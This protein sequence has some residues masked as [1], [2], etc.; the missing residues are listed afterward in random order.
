MFIFSDLI[1]EAMAT[2]IRPGLL[3]ALTAKPAAFQYR[4]NALTNQIPITVAARAGGREDFH[5][6]GFMASL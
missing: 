3:F 1:Y 5:L 4:L 2:Q 6:G